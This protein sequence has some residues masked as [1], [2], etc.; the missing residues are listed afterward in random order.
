MKIILMSVL[1]YAMIIFAL[2]NTAEVTIDFHFRQLE[3]VTLYSVL[4]SSL[5]I[6]VISG[7]IMGYFENLSMKREIK[8]EKRLRGELEI[9]IENLRTL[10]LTTTNKL[11]ED[12]ELYEEKDDL[13]KA[14]D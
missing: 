1:V 10:P 13:V 6:G 11:K 5:L 12:E 4:L 8:K 9:E 2:D 7:V 14:I 3:N